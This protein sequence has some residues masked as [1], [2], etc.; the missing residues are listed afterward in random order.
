MRGGEAERKEGVR[1]SF[2]F[3]VKQLDM[4]LDA[5]TEMGDTGEDCT[6]GKSGEKENQQ[7]FSI[8]QVISVSILPHST[9]R[10]TLWVFHTHQFHRSVK[11]L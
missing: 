10:N 1:V 2:R 9:L 6:Y 8:S 11:N 4:P 5:F 7:L 3:G